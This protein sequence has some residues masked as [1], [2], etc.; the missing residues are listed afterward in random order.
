MWLLTFLAKP[1]LLI[2]PF[3][4]VSILNYELGEFTRRCGISNPTYVHVPLFSAPRSQTTSGCGLELLQKK[5]CYVH[6]WSLC[7]VISAVTV[8]VHIDGCLRL[9][10]CLKV[11]NLQNI[12]RLSFACDWHRN[13]LYET[14]L[15]PCAKQ[16]RKH[17]H[18]VCRQFRV[19]RHEHSRENVSHNRTLLIFQGLR[20]NTVHKS[21]S[22]FL[23]PCNLCNSFLLFCL[24]LQRHFHGQKS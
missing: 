7:I 4:C 22:L 10:P 12:F 18:A 6:V 8:Y 3:T 9:I 11:P 20:I 15:R 14:R 19:Y 24:W 16:T 2:V 13:L 5:N 17:G 21:L 23:W 1:S